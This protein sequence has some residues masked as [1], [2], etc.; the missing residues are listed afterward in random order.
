MIKLWRSFPCWL[1]L[2][3]LVSFSGDADCQTRVYEKGPLTDLADVHAIVNALIKSPAIGARLRED[4]MTVSRMTRQNIQ[5]GVD[6]FVLY[7]HTCAMCNPG[8]AKKGFI[9]I[10]VDERPTYMDGAIEYT[11]SFSIESVVRKSPETQK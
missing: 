3:M 4:Q 9:S 11:V 8:E 7:V 1:A 5:P 2:I 6:E 10:I